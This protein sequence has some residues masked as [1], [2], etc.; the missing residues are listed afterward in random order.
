MNN[1]GWKTMTAGIGMMISGLLGG[2]LGVV[3]FDS[4]LSLPLV[5]AAQM[6]LNGLGFVGVRVALPKLLSK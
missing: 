5:D 1:L 6:F 2:I 4:P 3:N